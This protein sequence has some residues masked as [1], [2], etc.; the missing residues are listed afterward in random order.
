MHSFVPTVLYILTTAHD[1]WNT[2]PS[3][4]VVHNELVWAQPEFVLSA[5]TVDVRV[6]KVNVCFAAVMQPVFQR[7]S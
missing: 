5:T 7:V 1:P 4:G 2:L 6:Q 3:A